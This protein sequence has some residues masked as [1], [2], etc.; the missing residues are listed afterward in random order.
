[1]APSDSASRLQVGA[2]SPQGQ[3]AGSPVETAGAD[4]KADRIEPMTG[5]REAFNAKFDRE[6]ATAARIGAPITATGYLHLHLAEAMSGARA[7]L[8]SRQ[9][10]SGDPQVTLSED[11]YEK[12]FAAF[13]DGDTAAGVTRLR[14]WV[15]PEDLL[16]IVDRNRP[17]YEA[18]A[19]LPNAPNAALDY[20]HGPKGP[21]GWSPSV[22]IAMGSSLEVRLRESLPRMTQRLLAVTGKKRTAAK[23]AGKQPDA[24][25]P[26]ELV[27]SHK[28]DWAIA[29]AMVAFGIPGAV[30]KEGALALRDDVSTSYRRVRVEWNKTAH[31]VR[32][33]DPV[34]ASIEEVAAAVLKSPTEAYRIRRVGD[35]FVIPKDADVTQGA[36]ETQADATHLAFGPDA[37]RLETVEVERAMKDDVQAKAPAGVS[38]A[39]LQA[40]WTRVSEQLT[41]LSIVVR[42]YGLEVHLIAAVERHKAHRLDLAT[43]SAKDAIVRAELFARQEELLTRIAA[44][45]GSIVGESKQRAMPTKG[46]VA[47]SAKAGNAHASAD[48]TRMALLKLVGAAG[49][50]H[51]PETGAAVFAEAHSARRDTML[52]TFEELLGDI[53]TQIEIARLTMANTA[54]R[55][56]SSKA[57]FKTSLQERADALRARLAALRSKLLA[58]TADSAEVEALYAAIDALRFETSVIASIGQLGDAFDT[59]DKL[60]D[61]GWTVFSELMTN[62]DLMDLAQQKDT[63]RLEQSRQAAFALRGDLQT[64]H[65]KWLKVQAQANTVAEQLTAGGV[66]DPHDKALAIVAPQLAIIQGDLAK[67]GGQ[68]KVREFL[69]EAYDK[70]KSAERRAMILK[71]AAMI[72]FAIVS[73][74]VGAMAEG[75][76]GALFGPGLA[77]SAAG[78][79]VE[80]TTFTL[81]NAALSEDSLAHAFV[82]NFAGNLATFAALRGVSKVLSGSAIGKTLA[83]V[84][85]GER[86][87]LLAGLAAK[88]GAITATTLERER[89]I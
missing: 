64:V 30:V 34:D 36:G 21:A 89:A 6:L 35:L 27:P 85:A 19:A 49:L 67:L 23:S 80:T 74:G 45:I 24:I 20:G 84:A 38:F 41:G 72:G 81:L 54:A 2:S 69:T 51:L 73:S 52:T 61:S 7:F 88:A 59:L 78:L 56:R 55:T 12:L 44:D 1:M 77:A 28:L 15:A 83:A 53:S 17:L 62:G 10:P 37:A 8:S 9:L 48:A 57:V 71:V 63:N 47:K 14:N 46:G 75:G 58:G 79:I 11:F 68:A 66:S 60:E 39:T 33:I 13:R 29:R 5:A 76:A 32:A 42:E 22:G 3:H 65:S 40:A 25:Q 26:E 86:V 50:A 16:A 43:L 70:V 18:D 87:S 4:A 31:A 82:S